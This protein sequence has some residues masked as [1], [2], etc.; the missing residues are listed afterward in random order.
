[1]S[2][3]IFSSDD[4]DILEVFIVNVATIKPFLHLE[5]IPLFS[6]VGWLVYVSQLSCTYSGF[7]RNAIQ[8]MKMEVKSVKKCVCSGEIS[9]T[10]NLKSV[11]KKTCVYGM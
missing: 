4:G 7:Y 5:V 9:V 6:K 10:G 8:V 11:Q 1:M 2:E 3:L